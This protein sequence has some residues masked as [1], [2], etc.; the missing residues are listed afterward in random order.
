MDIEQMQCVLAVVEN[1]TFLE[2][3]EVMNRSQSSLSKAIKRLE[4]ELGITIFQRTTRR[5]T[6]TPAGEEIVAHMEH[7]LNEYEGIQN[8]V[9]QYH[10]IEQ[11]ELRIGSIYFGYNNILVPLVADYMNQNPMMDVS[12]TEST[13]TPL[14]KA[15]DQHTLDVVFV[16]SM[17]LQNG[18]RDNFSK[19][20][21]YISASFSID[22]YYVIVGRKHPLAA[23]EKLTYRDLEGQ[24]LIT[25]DKTMDVYHKAVNKVFEDN[26]VHVHIATH[27]TNVRSVLHMVSQNIGIAI[28]SK[29]VVEESD[30]LVM[31]PLE[32]PLVRDTQMVILNQR[33]VPKQIRSFYN[34][35]LQKAEEAKQDQV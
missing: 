20:P 25:T 35:V 10:A 19:D 12:M 7:I 14:L 34:F 16:S 33:K 8:V 23:R 13:T 18:E 27:C 9:Q 31:I 4:E 11:S 29:L 30:D 21:R 28:L 32:N 24:R 22:P 6:L 5:V 15:L 1:K 2:A 17:Y 3:A 26:D